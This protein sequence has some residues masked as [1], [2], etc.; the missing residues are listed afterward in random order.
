MVVFLFPEN[1]INPL[2][3]HSASTVFQ[4][5]ALS[6]MAPFPGKKFEEG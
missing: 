6:I 3:T 5:I 1:R 2:K 4:G